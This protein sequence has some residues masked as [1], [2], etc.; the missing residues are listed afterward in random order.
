[1]IFMSRKDIKERANKYGKD[2]DIDDAIRDMTEY[3]NELMNKFDEND[4][5]IDEMLDQVINQIDGIKL[6]AQ[7]IGTAINNQKEMIKKLNSK[8]EKARINLQKRS[9]ALEGVL[10]QYRRTNRMCIDLI[11]M[12]VLLIIVGII[13]SV[14]KKKN[15]IF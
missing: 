5:E 4:A 2:D 13:I 8:A 1:M 15:Y 14:L 12:C 6:H 9:S 11:L 3:E 7:N 10:Q